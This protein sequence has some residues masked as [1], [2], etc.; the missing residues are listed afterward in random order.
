MA[1]APFNGEEAFPVRH[2]YV[3]NKSGIPIS[4]AL[5]E[6]C[7]KKLREEG[8]PEYVWAVVI[9]LFMSAVALFFPEA[10]AEPPPLS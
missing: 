6:S 4:D 7:K 3:C 8:V 1:L 2:C 9:V 5:C 10:S